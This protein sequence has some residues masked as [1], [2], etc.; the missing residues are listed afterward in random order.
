MTTAQKEAMA[1][2]D[3]IDANAVR[4]PSTGWIWKDD[5]RRRECIAEIVI[6]EAAKCANQDAS[7]ERQQ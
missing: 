4:F 2:M 5:I 3:S 6:R 7:V 1:Y